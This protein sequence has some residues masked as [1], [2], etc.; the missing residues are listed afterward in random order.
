MIL[1]RFLLQDFKHPHTDVIPLEVPEG[2]ILRKA[3]VLHDGI[4]L[5]YEIPTLHV[6]A[7][8][9]KFAIIKDALVPANSQYVD[10][11]EAI[12]ETEEFAADGTPIQ[13]VVIYPLYYINQ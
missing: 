5:M 12:V 2:S 6:K 8:T 9:D 3:L 4:Y 11:L 7:R 1:E 13:S 10:I